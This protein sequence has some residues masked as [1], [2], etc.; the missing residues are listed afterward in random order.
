M[1]QAEGSG[2]D[3]LGHNAKVETIDEVT[4]RIAVSIPAEKVDQ[5]FNRAL[6][7]AQKSAHLKGFRPGKAP[8]DLVKKTH[9]PR[10]QFDV[11]DRLI[12]QSLQDIIKGMSETVIGKPSI[13]LENLE[14]GKPLK[15]TAQMEIW[16]EPKIKD[17]KSVAVSIVKREVSDAEI[18]KV[19]TKFLES[20]ADLKPLEGRSVVAIGDVVD[21]ELI[22]IRDGQ[23]SE[24]KEPFVVPVGDNMLPEELEQALVGMEAGSHKDV[25]LALGKSQGKDENGDNKPNYRLVVKALKSRIMPEV[26][27]EFIKAAGIPGIETVL[28]FRADVRKRLEEEQEAQKQEDLN[29]AILEKIVAAN[30]FKVPLTLVDDEI[31]NMVA[32]IGGS[33]D[34]QIDPAKLNP[35]PFRKAFGE[36][37]E[38]RVRSTILIDRIAEVEQLKADDDDFEKH[39]IDLAAKHN[40]EVATVKDI[41]SKEDTRVTVLLNLTRDK[42]L[43]WLREQSKISYT[44]KPAEEAD[45]SA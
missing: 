1:A 33:R 44:D 17:Y 31:K 12:S 6:D 5:E 36:Q 32:A 29:L 37:A 13:E 23:P 45:K 25:Y 16:P 11:A 42:V 14:S 22:E 38:K 15:F 26:T 35:E 34:R 21:A 2:S 41:L 3:E 8:R 10:L 24:D 9:G 7:Q 4:R 20:K 19:V 40:T 18:D 28:E 27:D 39:C 30:E 43:A